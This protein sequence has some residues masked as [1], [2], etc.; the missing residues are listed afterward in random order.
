MAKLPELEDNLRNAVRELTRRETSM[1][2]SANKYL[3]AEK[4]ANQDLRDQLKR[5]ER[6][7]EHQSSSS[8][9]HITELNKLLAGEAAKA[10][11]FEATAEAMKAQLESTVQ[12]ASRPSGTKIMFK[13]LQDRSAPSHQTACT[14]QLTNLVL[15]MC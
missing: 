14:S 7:L 11:K 9:A 5:K 12:Q 8:Q 2:D 4:Q 6:E 1:L 3:A 13:D 15:C 10:A